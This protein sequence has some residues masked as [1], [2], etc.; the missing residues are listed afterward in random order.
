MS[1]LSVVFS[2]RTD[3][4]LEHHNIFHGV[5]GDAD[6]YISCCPKTATDIEA[7][8]EL[9]K[10]KGICTDPIPYETNVECMFFNRK[11]AFDMIQDSER[12][13][14]SCRFDL[15][16][17]EMFSIHEFLEDN[18]IYIPY[19]ED[20]GG[21]NDRLAFGNYESM[22]VY[23]NAVVNQEYHPETALKLYLDKV[24]L[25]VVRFKSRMDLKSSTIR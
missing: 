9:Y 11:R 25:N 24:G 18:T 5:F 12:V 3:K 6:Y 21:V 23:C 10:P 16:I 1:K 17:H 2:G 15:Y 4:A 19:G 22:K 8:T 13:V 7:I 14:I 20:H